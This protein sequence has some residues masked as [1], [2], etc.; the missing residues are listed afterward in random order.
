[1][2]TTF[3]FIIAAMA[4]SAVLTSCQK[5]MAIENTASSTDGVR[6]ISAS[7]SAP[8]K[9]TLDTDG[10]TPKFV[11]GETIKVSNATESQVRTISIDASG[12][13]YFSTSLTGTLTA[14]YPSTAAKMNGAVIDNSA[15]LV[16]TVQDGTFEG[17]NIAMATGITTSATFTNKTAVIA[18]TPGAGVNTKYVE[19]ITAGPEIANSKSGAYTKLNKIH[20]NTTSA[21]PV[22]VSILVPSGLKI[23]NLSFA[24]GSNIKT[25][26]DNTTA[27]A[28]NTINTVGNTGWDTPYVE[29][30][31]LKWATMNVGATSATEAGKYFMWGET[32]GITPSGSSFSFPDS[33]YYSADNTSWNSTKGFAWENCPHTNGLYVGSGESKKLNVFTKYT[34]NSNYAYSGTADG[35]SILESADDAATANWG[36]SWRMPTGGTNAGDFIDLF[37]ACGIASG[38]QEELIGV[39][40]TKNKGVYWCNDY[41]DDGSGVKGALFIAEDNGTH[42]FFPAAGFGEKENL[43]KSGINCYFW[44]RTI[45]SGTNSYILFITNENKFGVAVS[46]KEKYYGY[47]VR[48]VSD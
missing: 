18:I 39:K 46:A 12:N 42:L 23:Q 26:K 11:G 28:V 1:M 19:V 24:D 25:A 3:K 44:S 35:L 9:S 20:V 7:F 2:K 13:P 45:S 27:I 36:G 29:I 34:T 30:N 21:D 43:Y 38:F 40:G 10:K 15:V 33:K 48:P 8:T 47:F 16:S 5:E 37:N 41:Y 31:G 22:Y 17:A 4:A 14:V 6:V 32:T